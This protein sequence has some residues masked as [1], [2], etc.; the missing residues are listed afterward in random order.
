MDLNKK[1]VS[2]KWESI[3][4]PL[5]ENKTNWLNEYKNNFFD[6]Q[7]FDNTTYSGLTTDNE[8]F[9][10]LLP[11]AMKITAKTLGLDLVDVKPIGGTV[12]GKSKEQQLRE[13]RVNKLRKLDGKEPNVKLKDDIEIPIGPTGQLLYVDYQYNTGNTQN[14][15]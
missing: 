15:I 2:K 3:I 10:N 8:N 7:I 4:E 9:K 6:Q 1:N 12:P 5:N 13:D 14:N 11:T